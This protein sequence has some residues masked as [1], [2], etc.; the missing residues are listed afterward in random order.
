MTI[1]K[2]KQGE[3]SAP[4]W[5]DLVDEEVNVSPPIWNGKLS[6]RSLK[7]MLK[8]VIGKNNKVEAVAAR[9]YPVKCLCY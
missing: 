7:F 3:L 5:A 2:E 9:V 6:P 8:S 1:S 4:W